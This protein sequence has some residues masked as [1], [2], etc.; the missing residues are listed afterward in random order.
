MCKDTENVTRNSHHE[1][2]IPKEN[3][4][5]TEKQV[6]L[7]GNVDM[8]IYNRNSGDD[9]RL[10]GNETVMSNST[11]PTAS[12]ESDV[13]VEYLEVNEHSPYSGQDCALPKQDTDVCNTESVPEQS[14]IDTQT[15]RINTH[16]DCTPEKVPKNSTPCIGL[17]S[18]TS[19][20]DSET[21]P[22]QN[23]TLVG[24]STSNEDSENDD[25][26]SEQQN[27][28]GTKPVFSIVDEVNQAVFEH[29]FLEK[30]DVFI[31]KTDKKFA[32]LRLI[33]SNLKIKKNVI[34]DDENRVQTENKSS[35][36]EHF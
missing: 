9:S 30:T 15:I 2:S 33:I 27:M 6:A 21:I 20:S 4:F 22:G 18:S 10:G 14:R 7:I 36:Q 16:A 8:D 13:I 11:S 35:T 31:N 17:C 34:N 12:N 26:I 1:N 32:S 29:E 3:G 24:Y 19:Q 23:V 28:G 25:L 5:N